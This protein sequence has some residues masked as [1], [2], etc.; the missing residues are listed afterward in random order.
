M[1]AN[2][3]NIKSW[4]NQK[5]I[6]WRNKQNNR[7]AGITQFAEYLGLSRSDMSNYIYRG[8]IPTRENMETIASVLGNEFYRVCGVEPPLDPLQR[9]VVDSMEKLA[10]DQREYLRDEVNKLLSQLEARRAATENRKHRTGPLSGH[11]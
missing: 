1:V 4:L 10:D 7:R 8:S 2:K 9:F 5:Y 3:E 11:A 6:D